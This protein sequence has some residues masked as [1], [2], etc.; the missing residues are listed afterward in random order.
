MAKVISYKLEKFEGPLDLLLHLIEKDKINIYDIPIANITGQYLEYMQRM[1]NEDLDLMSEF[2]VMAA[3]LL[4]IKARMLLPKEID[5]ESKEEID[6]REE[7]VE[8]L[9]EYK[10]FKI[11]AGELADREFE[12]QRVLYKEGGLPPEIAKYEAPIDL[13]EL[14]KGVELYRLREIY[15]EVL[16]R[17]ENR[18]DRQ[19]SNFGTIK[20]EPISLNERITSLLHFARQERRF[21]FRRLIEKE[22]TKL[23]LVITFLALLELMK[24]GKISIVQEELFCDIEIEISEEAEEGDE[25]DL[26]EVEE[27]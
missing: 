11:M 10:K 12:A 2:L 8:R 7:L 3:T 5:E 4:D 16:R 18:I 6:P 22:P 19:R 23:N 26:T 20:K 24:L 1:E 27:I 13:D 21:S 9:I 25:I 14:F 17:K 15:E